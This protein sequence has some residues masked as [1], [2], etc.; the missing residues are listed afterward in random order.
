MSLRTWLRIETTGLLLGRRAV[1]VSASAPASG[2]GLV[3][4]S[5]RAGFVVTNFGFALSKD[6]S[7]TGACPHGWTTGL[8]EQYADTPEGHRND[9]ESE[10]DYSRRLAAGAQKL[11]MAPNGQNICMNPEAG[12]TGP[13]LAHGGRA[14]YSGLRH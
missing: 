3:R 6:A 14:Q 1:A 7:E 10:Q 8:R 13:P 11:S 2:S 9:G 4:A 5:G 12:R